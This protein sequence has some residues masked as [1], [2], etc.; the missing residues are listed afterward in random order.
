MMNELAIPKCGYFRKN[1]RVRPSKEPDLLT[2]IREKRKLEPD[3]EKGITD[4]VTVYVQEIIGRRVKEE[5]DKFDEYVDAPGKAE[6]VGA[7]K[8]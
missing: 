1:C 3:I 7:G 2:L 4:L 8:K 6:P 5:P